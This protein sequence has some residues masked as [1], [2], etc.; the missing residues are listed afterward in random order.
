MDAII[1]SSVYM[2]QIA[3]KK[4]NLHVHIST[5]CSILN[6]KEIEFFKSIG[7][8]RVVLG[9]ECSLDN[10][11]D[12]T[13]EEIAEIEVFIHGGMCS[14]YS[15][16][17]M[18][19]NVM[20]NRDANR[21][22]CA[23][24]CR[25]KY[26]IF[27]KNNNKLNPDNTYF[28]M[29]S[30]DLCALSLMPEMLKANID[31]FKIEGRMKSLNYIACVCKAYRLCIDDYLNGQPFDL[32]KYYNVIKYCE[33]RDTGIG[34]LK[35]NISVNEQLFILDN[36][37]KRTGEFVGIVKDYDKKT[38]LATIYLR[39]KIMVNKDYLVFSPKKEDRL[40]HINKFIV[41][42]NDNYESYSV[43]NDLISFECEETLEEFD[44]IRLKL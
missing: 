28:S 19:S 8:Q 18:L 2:A 39:N 30:K 22:G 25:W 43:A 11:I 37:C 27:D 42:N 3:I 38:K 29:S 35:G 4:T 6:I 16:K 31:S 15:G 23:H 40:I 26:D 24:S 7:C 14:S 20:T 41:N 9:R 5:Q 17:C 12:I 1:T 13:K 36:E 21:G 32:N 33:H 10:I 34:F 44:S